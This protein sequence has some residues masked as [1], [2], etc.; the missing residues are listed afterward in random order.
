MSSKEVTQTLPLPLLNASKAIFRFISDSGRDKVFMTA[1]TQ[2]FDQGLLNS[3]LLTCSAKQI[4]S[5]LANSS[6]AK[7]TKT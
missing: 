5:A 3:G 4:Y 1:D 2:L 7:T 6:Y